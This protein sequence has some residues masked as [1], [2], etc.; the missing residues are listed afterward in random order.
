MLE[1]IEMSRTKLSVRLFRADDLDAI[2]RL[3]QR[4]ASGGAADRMFPGR[5][6]GSDEDGPLRSRLFVAADGSEI[7][8]G[9][10][11]REQEFWVS[12]QAVRAGWVKYPVA[13]S[14]VDA[15]FAGVPAALI[16]HLR[17]EQ[18][19]LMALGLGGHRGP[20]AQLLNAMRWTGSIVPF[21]FRV[22]RP[23]RVL[24]RL[25]YL[26][27]TP[28]RRLALDGLAYSGLSW[29]FNKALVGARTLRS[30]KPAEHSAAVAETFES[31]ADAIWA[32]SRS[33]YGFVASRSVPTMNAAYPEG[34]PGLARLRVSSPDREIGWVCAVR[35]TPDRAQVARYFGDLTIGLLADVWADPADALTVTAAG[36]QHLLDSGVDLLVSNQA[37][38]AWAGALQALGFVRGPS[39]FAFYRSP[40]MEKLLAQPAARAG[41]YH[42]TR[43]DCD[44]PSWS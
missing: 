16:L 31:W 19:R 11:L 17:R 38:P 30:E 2:K 42:L 25:S 44:G 23:A 3:N 9:V 15:E 6:N 14:L 21:Y 41:G 10:W 22:V 29:V 18:P 13:E 20:F 8:G 4:L 27:T 35:M 34:A 37:H 32:T 12:G 7:R 28:V 39:N 1:K 5:T 43:G 36:V 26:R 33:R 24:R 40:E